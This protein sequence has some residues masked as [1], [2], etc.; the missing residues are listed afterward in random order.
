V[1]R[2]VDDHTQASSPAADEAD[3]GSSS[4]FVAMADA[5]PRLH[6][7]VRRVRLGAILRSLLMLTCSAGLL[8]G[9]AVVVDP[10][11]LRGDSEASQPRT[12]PRDL[13]RD[14]ARSLADLISN[15]HEVLAVHEPGASPYSEIVLWVNDDTNPGTIDPK[16]VAIIS[17][18]RLFHTI[19]VYSMESGGGAVARAPAMGNTA[20]QAPARDEG[21]MPRQGGPR[22]GVFF[23]GVPLD[24]AAVVQPSFCDRWRAAPAVQPRVIA[25]GISDMKIERTGQ[26]SLG[27]SLLRLS[28]RW[29]GDSADGAVEASALIDLERGRNRA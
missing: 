7:C 15:C 20:I 10:Q 17:H 2:D 18:S 25:S 6:R 3:T 28:L 26:A 5:F 14:Y 12:E 24:R 8:I 23:D 16:E 13:H 22:A 4:R 19:T 9:A 1:Q 11:Q 21:L 27:L 29:I